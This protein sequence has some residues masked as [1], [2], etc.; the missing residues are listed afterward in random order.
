MR[1]TK[2]IRESTDNVFVGKAVDGRFFDEDDKFGVA[3]FFH[4]FLVRVGFGFDGDS[5]SDL[6]ASPAAG[7]AAEIAVP[8]KTARGAGCE[9]RIAVGFERYLF[10]DEAFNIKYVALLVWRGK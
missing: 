4:L 6:T 7:R 9:C 1:N 10:A 2:I 3:D 8:S 5:H